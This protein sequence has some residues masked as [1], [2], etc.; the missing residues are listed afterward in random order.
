[1]VR[2]YPKFSVC[3]SHMFF[4]WLVR[5]FLDLPYYNREAF[6]SCLFLLIDFYLCN[7]PEEMHVW[8]WIEPEKHL[9]FCW[10]L[11][12]RSNWEFF[13]V[14]CSTWGSVCSWKKKIIKEINN[15]IIGL[16]LT[17]AERHNLVL[18]LSWKRFGRAS[19]PVLREILTVHG[20]WSCGLS[21]ICEFKSGLLI[22]SLL[23]L[24]FLSSGCFFFAAAVFHNINAPHRCVCVCGGGGG[25]RGRWRGEVLE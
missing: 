17:A 25:W 7:R 9:G 22:Y 12:V 4:L 18:R 5:A 1:M 19:V 14:M 23:G 13:F 6:W 3:L 8:S 21:L 10:F 2:D 24:R 11:V 15:K 20:A 16:V